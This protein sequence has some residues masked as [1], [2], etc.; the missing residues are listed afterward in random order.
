MLLAKLRDGAGAGTAR[1]ALEMATLGGAGCLGRDGE[2]G[3][4]RA[5]RRRRRRRLAAGRP[6]VRRRDR[7]PGRGLAAL[8]PGRGAPHGRPRPAGR[9]RRTC[10]STRTLDE[11]LRRPPSVVARGS[12][13]VTAGS[14]ATADAAQ[15]VLAM[16]ARSV[17]PARCARPCR[18]VARRRGRRLLHRSGTPS[19]APPFGTVDG[20]SGDVEPLVRR[21]SVPTP[22]T[23]DS[24]VMVGD[25]IT[26]GSQDGVE[27]ELAALGLDDVEIDAVSGRRMRRRRHRATSGLDVVDG[28]R[29]VRS[30]RPVGRSPSAPTTS[31]TTRPRGVRPRRSTSCSRPCRTTRRWCGSTPTSTSEPDESAAFNDVAAGCRWRHAAGRCVVD[32]SSIAA[33]DGVL[34]RRRAPVG[35]TGIA[36]RSPTRVVAAVDACV[37]LSD[38]GVRLP[39]R[40]WPKR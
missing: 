15:T 21:S 10:S 28:D 40:D 13:V 5:G 7:R 34:R 22:W 8:R 14:A 32:W 4:L 19:T 31:A 24:V 1:M 17:D 39:Q 25:S 20:A 33:E 37:G 18:C 29:R 36:G 23:V 2:L 12:S 38:D 30:A 3:V 26:V 11:M 27:D 16:N 9:A 6:V 35:A